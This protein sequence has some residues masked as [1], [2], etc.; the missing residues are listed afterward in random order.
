MAKYAIYHC[1]LIADCCCDCC[2]F[3]FDNLGRF[4]LLTPLALMGRQH[5]AVFVA[6]PFKSSGVLNYDTQVPSLNTDKLVIGLT[7]MPGSGK[8]LVVKA[9]QEHG[10]DMVTMGDVIR[11]ETTK[12]GLELNP[13][14]VG[15]VMLQLR[16]EGGDRVIAQKCIPKI[17]QKPT[18]K[19]IVDGL[20]SYIE[21]D[22]FKTQLPNFVL[23]TV[24]AAPKV[25][26]ERLS[27]R[28][29]SDDP[30]TWEVFLERDM[31][32][33]SVGIGYA[34]ALSEHVIINDDTKE[35]LNATVAEVLQKVEK[36]WS[37]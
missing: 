3:G 25:R 34:I 32:E 29:R 17:Q 26:F 35:K 13:A 31:R 23:I 16:A 12:R 7:G 18:D 9:A 6:N 30:K 14:N 33:L 36:K 1:G 10:Y 24:H 15:K 2:G 19:V 21:A 8:S 5:C 11:E 4:L 27:N 22:T 20:R 37:N 28:G